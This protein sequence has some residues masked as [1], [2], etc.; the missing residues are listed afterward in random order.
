MTEST[1]NWPKVLIEATDLLDQDT[2]Q[3]HC[4]E[5]W[6]VAQKLAQLVPDDAL[7]LADLAEPLP[8]ADVLYLLSL[9]L[10]LAFE[11]GLLPPLQQTA[12][13][14]WERD[15]R[16]QTTLLTAIQQFAYHQGAWDYAW[17]VC[18]R[19]VAEWQ[20]RLEHDPDFGLLAAIRSQGSDAA[21]SDIRAAIGL[22]WA[23]SYNQGRADHM[24]GRYTV[25][26]QGLF[27][28]GA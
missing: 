1:G 24:A 3:D 27:H 4:G 5:I 19:P 11:A 15:H 21:L 8:P 13:L 6:R 9:A 22:V 20:V 7:S 18:A 16:D 14:V 10:S 26:E 2:I 23:T 25:P 12:R 28:H 17:M